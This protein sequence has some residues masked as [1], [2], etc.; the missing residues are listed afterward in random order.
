MKRLPAVICA[1][2][3]VSTAIISV[4]AEDAGYSEP[5][6]T[7]SDAMPVVLADTGV[8]S[9]PVGE[10]TISGDDLSSDDY[11]YSED[12]AGC[13]WLTIQ[14][15]KAMTISSSAEYVTYHIL[16][17]SADGAD[18]TLENVNIETSSGY[19]FCI[20]EGTGN[21]IITLKGCNRLYAG[22][23]YAGLQKDSSNLLTIQG[24]GELS[25][26][27]GL[28][29]AG[30][31]GGSQG[32]G[33]DITINGG[34]IKAIASG[35]S[36][37]GAGI[38]GGSHG[39]GSN[40]TITNGKV[41]AEGGG[42]AGIGGGS[43]GDGVNIIIEGGDIT[44]NFGGNSGSAGIGGGEGGKA[45][46]IHISGGK[47]TATSWVGAGIG[48]GSGREGTD[49]RI[50]GDAYVDVTSRYGAGIGGGSSSAPSDVTIEGSATVIATSSQGVG[51]G[52]KTSAG[53]AVTITGGNITA[54]GQDAG[55]G[56]QYSTVRINGAGSASFPWVFTNKITRVN[57][58]VPYSSCIVFD[59]AHKG[60]YADYPADGVVY[61]EVDLKDLT[62]SYTLESDK[63][64]RVQGGTIFKTAGKLIL[65]GTLYIEAGAT[66]DKYDKIDIEGGQILHEDRSPYVEVKVEDGVNEFIC[67]ICGTKHVHEWTVW[68]DADADKHTRTCPSQKDC[69]VFKNDCTCSM[70]DEG[71]HDYDLDHP[72]IQGRQ[73]YYCCKDCGHEYIVDIPIIYLIKV[74]G[75]TG[76]PLAGAQFGLYSD[77]RCTDANRIAAGTTETDEDN[78]AVVSFDIKQLGRTYYIRETAAPDGYRVSREVFQ[79]VVG[80]DGKVTY[81]TAGSA[82]TSETV[83]VCKNYDSTSDVV[84]VIPDNST[85]DDVEVIPDSST[86]DDVE[87]I[88][89]NSTSDPAKVVEEDAE[90]ET[91]HA[92]SPKTGDT[93]VFGTAGLTIL[94][95]I[96]CAA[97]LVA[98]VQKRKRKNSDD[99]ETDVSSM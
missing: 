88:P 93:G 55:I 32:N 47:I 3:I 23:D 39:N 95:G 9:V 16:V 21:V 77:E 1:F 61:G 8:I 31:G 83:P 76:A 36:G 33:S 80:A 82:T 29:G 70:T 97:F 85:P 4:N 87:V 19:A 11:S 62:E 6:Q 60:T 89:D 74:D 99:N 66:L 38:G 44:A 86:P 37:G 24:D 94:S 41:F 34:N 10:L 13:G 91:P 54:T 35:N 46:K 40:I 30:I 12:G 67:D 63:L 22:L 56:G 65:K 71:E 58:S 53:C 17:D 59:E 27:G 69:S 7:V 79:A 92:V 28:G 64:L 45:E 50:S 73:L 48:G 43:Y 78:H 42:G 51:I 81:G 68:V 84:E 96:T 98:G 52:S 5:E 90:T 20:A 15:S 25:A 49:I 18:L 14:S 57:T 2:L 75:E 26:M 72:E